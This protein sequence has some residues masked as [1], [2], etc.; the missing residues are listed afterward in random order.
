[1][2][3]MT[4]IKNEVYPLSGDF[5]YKNIPEAAST[6]I[7]VDGEAVEIEGVLTPMTDIQSTLEFTAPNGAQITERRDI[8][9]PKSVAEDLLEGYDFATGQPI[10]NRVKLHALYNMFDLGLK[11]FK[12]STTPPETEE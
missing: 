10:L 7:A 1:M 2:I 11:E 3:D 8:K 9:L 6:L 4:I 5:L 12:P